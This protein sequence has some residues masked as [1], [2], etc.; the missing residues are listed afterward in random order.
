VAVKEI[1][2]PNWNWFIGASILAV[3]LLGPYA[4]LPDLIGGIAL[5]AVLNWKLPLGG[6][7]DSRQKKM[8]K[9]R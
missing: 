5:A 2:A 1:V 6:G 3:G 7:G 8:R 4:P 9:G